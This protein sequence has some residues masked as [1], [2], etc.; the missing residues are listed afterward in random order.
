MKP[1]QEVNYL[2]NVYII[3][4]NLCFIF[5][6]KNQHFQVLQDHL[7]LTQ[8][9]LSSHICNASICL[10]VWLTLKFINLIILSWNI[11]IEQKSINKI[12][13]IEK[14]PRKMKKHHIA[15]TTSTHYLLTDW[16]R[17]TPKYQGCGGKHVVFMI[18]SKISYFVIR[19]KRSGCT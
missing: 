11:R 13:C 10:F 19:F 6:K 16:V 2:V 9:S 12:I 8:N 5:P 14:F 15:H 18:W 7:P 4:F 17:D 3:S 1:F